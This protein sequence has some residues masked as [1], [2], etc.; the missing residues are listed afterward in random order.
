MSIYHE[1]YRL[2]IVDEY[3]RNFSKFSSPY[4]PEQN[5]VAERKNKILIEADRTMLNGLVLSKH[6]WT[7]AV[8]IACYT[9]N[10]SIIVKR[11]DKTPYEIFK[12]RI[13]DISYFHVSGCPV[14]IYNHKDHL[15]K[16]NAKADDGYFLGYSSVLKAFSVYNTRRQQIKETYHVTFNESMEAIRFTNT[17]VDEIGIDDSSRYPPDEFLH[18]DDPSRQY[19]V[20]YDISYYVIPHRRS[21]TELTQE[22]HIPEVIVPN[23]HDVPLTENIKDPSDLIN[24][25][26]TYEQNVQDDQ[27]I[28]QPTDV[29]SGNNTEISRP[30]TEP[31][32]SDV[33]QSHIPSQASTSMLTKSMAAKLTATSA[34][35]CLFADFLSEIEPKK[36]SKALKHLGW[37]D[38]MQEELNQFYRNKVFRNKKDENGTT[39][40]NKAI[41]VAQG[42]SQEEGIDYDET[43]APVARMEAIRI[44]LAFATYMN[45]KV[46]QMDVKSAFLNGK[47]KEEVYVKQPPGFESSE[48]PDYVCKLDK[49]L[50]G[51]KQAPKAWYETL[52][53]FLIQNKFAKE[54]ID[55]TLFIY[56]SKGDVLLV[57]VYVDDII[58]GSTSYKL[59]KQFE[60]LMTKKFE[61]SMMGKLTY[62]LGFSS[63]KTPMVPPN[64]LGPDLAG[65]PV[66]ETSY[67]GMIGY[68]SNPKE[69]HLISVKRILIYLKG[70]PTLGLY[71][72]KCSSFDLKGYSNSDYVGCNMDIKSTSG[73]CQLLGGKLVCWSAKKQQSVAM[74]STEAEY[75]AAAGCCASIIW[76]K[77]QL[78]DYDIHYKMVTIFCDNTSSIAISNNLVLHSRTKHIDIRYYFI[79]DHILKGNIKLHFIP[80]KYQLA[81]IFTKP[82]DEPTFTRLK[83]ELGITAVAF[84]PFPSTDE[85]EKRPLK[86][87]LIKFLVSNGQR[88]LTLDFKTFCSSTGLDYNNGKY[89]EHSTPKVVKKELGK[90]A[91]NPSYLDKTSVL[92]NSFPVAWRIL[93][94]FVIQVLSGNYSSTEQ[95]NSTQQLLAYSLITRTE[96]GIG[97]IIYSDLS[98]GP[99]A[100]GALSKM[101]KRP[102][103]KKPPTKTKVTPPKTTKGSKQSHSV[104][105]GTV[106]DP[107]D[108][109][110]DIQLA[111]TG[112]PSTLDER[113]RKS[114]PLPEGTATHSKDSG[115]N[116]QPLDRDITFTTSDEGTAKTTPHPEG[117]RTGAKYQEDQTQ[118]SRLR[119]QSVTGNKDEA[120]E[121]E[122][123]I[124]GAGEEM[125][126][127]PQS[128]ETQHQ[129]SPQAS[130]TDSSSDKI[131]RKYD[132]TLPLTKQKL[133]KYLRKVSRVLF[134]RITKDQWEKHEEEVV[135]YVSLKAS[136]D[137]YYNENI[138]HKDQTDK[139]VEAFMSSLEK[140]STT[141]NDLYKGLEVITQLLKDI[142]TSVK[143]DSATNKKV[144]EASEHLAKISTQITEILSLVK[145]LDFSTQSTVKNIQDHAF[146]QEEASPDWMKSST[147]MAWNLGSR[148]SGLE[149]TQTHIQSSMS[150]LKED[151]SS[152]KFM[153]TKMYNAFRSQSSSAPSSSVT[154]TFALTDTLANVEGDNA[155][156]TATKEPSFHTK[157]ETDA[158]IQEKPKESKQS[159]DANIKEGKGIATDDQ[160]EDQ[161][162]L[163]KASS[164]VHPDLDK[165]DKEEEIK[166]AEEEA[167]LNAIS[168]T[169]VVKVIREEAKKLGIH[170]KG[171]ITTKAGELFKKA[172][173]AE[174][175]VLKRQHTEKVRKSLELIKHKYDNYMWT[176]SNRLKPEPITDIKIHPK[177]KP[178]VITVYRGTDGRNFDVHKPFFFGAF[179]ISKLDELREIIPKKKNIVS[180]LPTPEQAP[181]QSSG[182]KR[183]H[184]ELEPETRIPGLECN[185]ALPENVPFVNNMVIEE[186]EY[187]ILFT[188]EFGDQAFQRWSDIDIVGME[189]L[190]SYLVAASM[191]KSPENA[192]FGMK[193]RKLIVEYPDQEKLKSKKVK[194][195][196]LGYNMD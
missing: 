189:A 40:K 27:M 33:T 152:I 195:E 158:N 9:Q 112:L 148:I 95:V 23:E 24:T 104:S 188:D 120:Q 85:L 110:R 137:D 41:L 113:T 37:I 72:P 84:D 138:A 36:V 63:V 8:K 136:I 35:E 56:K 127:N 166:K 168:K 90:I 187:G 108:L 142:T 103:S 129:S 149:R 38:V 69:S 17:S 174:H 172:Q 175:E 125:D 68:Q 179:G 145:S 130:D 16:F 92:K 13:P 133:V 25:E 180:A 65:K 10:R 101:S 53:T 74:S 114:K 86:E 47:L 140:S 81:D 194:L 26:E 89:V 164:I 115:G 190:V 57:Q 134:E 43:F 73:A 48:F 181:S 39:T 121:S 60:K 105:S 160:A 64:N 102:K 183:K 153:M 147:N 1:K 14:F 55:N 11:H 119:Y 32:A 7:E 116:K 144:E 83:A 96:V 58:F 34:S 44:F 29:P 62:F 31:L 98:Q 59:C 154:P 177:T 141:I 61:M 106:P 52:S 30:F 159:T 131:L 193:L 2:V 46:Y 163:V 170:P 186:P 162:K 124:L 12:K 51:L 3:S 77:S 49:A 79:S 15:G 42:Y 111:T 178:V 117:S 169:E 71:Y 171:A 21:L 18:K 191:V 118:S 75:V 88:P 184:M 70:T 122:E 91:I 97:E 167:R 45:F 143:D 161:K 82:L 156:H 196:A 50:Y 146:K 109:E 78:S 185:R 4:T 157:G 192:R 151:T 128:A 76:L 150:S 132:D 100:S 67:R 107:Q 126:D 94:T 173:D 66:N 20:D 19:Q 6:F 87:F 99:E 135:H 182:R 80:T 155:T 22:N 176:V 93:F 28:N 5:G 123:D 165:P 139:L 54:R